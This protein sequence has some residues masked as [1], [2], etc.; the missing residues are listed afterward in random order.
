MAFLANMAVSILGGVKKIVDPIFESRPIT[1]L[2]NYIKKQLDGNSFCITIYS[3]K[4]PI[5]FNAVMHFF[6]KNKL[7]SLS[8]MTT[9]GQNERQETILQLGYRENCIEITRSLNTVNR[10]TGVVTNTKFMCYLSITR[11]RLD[12]TGSI[13]IER[14]D[15]K[16]CAV[17]DK[18]TNTKGELVDNPSNFTDSV[19]MKILEQMIDNW[20]FQYNE[21]LRNKLQV[22]AI[23]RDLKWYM[24]ETKLDL[25]PFSKLTLK[26][27]EQKSFEDVIDNILSPRS[28]L[29]GN[30]LLHGAPGDG[31][32]SIGKCIATSIKQKVAETTRHLYGNIYMIHLNT[33]GLTDCHLEQ[34]IDQVK[35]GNLICIEDVDSLMDQR[36]AN[37]LTEAGFTELLQGMVNV[38]RGKII[39][40]TTNHYERL[41]ERFTREGR[42][43][44]NYEI[45][46]PTEQQVQ[47]YVRNII[48]EGESYN[49]VMTQVLQYIED[50]TSQNKTVHMCNLE[51]LVQRLH[52]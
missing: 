47:K 41:T 37:S 15:F 14:L 6:T 5:T 49:N 50:M 44:L 10:S 26:D 7:E 34:L 45:T 29:N 20:V 18:I 2:T 23:G 40:M 19:Y 31:K 39:F 3:D 8:N 38:C 42:I 32:T 17:P 51:S 21:D 48:P 13:P 33:P 43:K 46:A 35:S 25:C 28:D 4:D 1:N 16:I 36:R 30:I 12:N 52:H 11:T 9:A 24:M 27:G 22:W